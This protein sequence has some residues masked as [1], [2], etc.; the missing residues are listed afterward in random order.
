M[1]DRTGLRGPRRLLQRIRDLMAEQD[2][3]QARLDRL[4]RI[5]AEETGSDVCSIYLVLPSGA[6]ELSATHGLKAEAVHSLRLARDEGLVGLVAQRARPVSVE[7]APTH[8]RFAYK[9]ETG[10]EPFKS[11]VGVPVLRGGRLVGVLTAQTMAVRPSTE[12]EI[13]TLQTVAML[14]AEI[15]ASGE[16][17][18]AEA[19]S[20]LELRA[21]GPERYAGAALAPGIAMGVA[22]IHEPHVA[23]A[24]M[25]AED[26]EAEE[27][28]LDVAVADLRRG[29]DELLESGRAPV[30]TPSRDVL[31]A[32]RMF[33]HDRGLDRAAARGGALRPHRRGG[34]GA[35][36][37]YPSRAADEG[38]RTPFPRAPA[39][40]RRPR[41]PAPAPSGRTG[42]RARHDR[43]CR[44]MPF[45]SRARSARPS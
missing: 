8:P 1:L 10:E 32:Y 20:D 3:A 30:G 26:A 15:V 11:F 25:I 33:A 14:L 34:S 27:A 7:D 44:P 6:L 39:R 42:R 36:A 12:E 29:L 13:E 23:S 2:Q 31:E 18:R 38:A 22:V 45:W 28:R 41:Q 43:P 5:I 17:I 37:Q 21:S 35:R 4:T 40:S 9:P 24:R 19:F 16:L